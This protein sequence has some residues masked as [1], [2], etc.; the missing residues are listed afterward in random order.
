M[1]Y[2]PP[3]P[4][5]PLGPNPGICENGKEEICN[6]P[7]IRD[8]VTV[9]YCSQHVWPERSLSRL[10]PWRRLGHVGKPHAVT[11]WSR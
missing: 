4:R 11:W 5:P 8:G 10:N 1:T 3:P 6:E 7:L 9:G 2:P